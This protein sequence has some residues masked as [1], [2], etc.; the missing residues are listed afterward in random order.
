MRAFFLFVSCAFAVARAQQTPNQE[1]LPESPATAPVPEELPLL[2][3]EIMLLP[4]TPPPTSTGARRG[5]LPPFKLKLEPLKI[6]PV[7]PPLAF[8]FEDTGTLAS[9]LRVKV[10]RFRFEGNG[11]F[12]DRELQRLV[13]RFSGREITGAELEEARQAVTMHYVERG[14]INSGALLPDQDLKDGVV[15]FKIVEGRLTGV[16]L[17]GN[18]WYRGWWLRHE[19]RYAAGRPLNFNRMKEGLQLLRENPNIKQINAELLPGG[20]PGESILKVSVEENQ[21]FRLSL[22]FSNRR[23]PSVGAEI[24]E[25]NA[26][27]LN[28]SGHDDPI[29]LRYGILHTTSETLDRWDASGLENK[30]GRA[31]V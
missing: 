28:L 1:P 10:K 20:K 7:L 11:A 4:Q 18:W 15:V 25:V 26:A 13:A 24:L 23:P 2:P 14:F 17:S 3:D 16:E 8:G 9:A 12:S 27:V 21:P 5:P 19:M 29:S 31:H 22:D 6:E 30:I